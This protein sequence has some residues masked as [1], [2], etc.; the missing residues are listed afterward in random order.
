LYYHEP[1]VKITYMHTAHHVIN[2]RLTYAC[3][4]GFGT[5]VAMRN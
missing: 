2:V 1:S 5:E 3:K 4:S